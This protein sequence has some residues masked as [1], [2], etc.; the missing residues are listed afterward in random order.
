[1]NA[2]QTLE[3]LVPP[4]RGCAL[5]M[6]STDHDGQLHCASPTVREVHG[7]QPVRMVRAAI[8]ACGPGAIHMD[9]TAWRTA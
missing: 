5:C 2:Q 9:M 3:L 6:H 8:A 7:L 1:M 4:L